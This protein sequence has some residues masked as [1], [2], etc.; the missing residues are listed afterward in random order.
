M[1]LIPMMTQPEQNSEMLKQIRKVVAAI[2]QIER[3]SV[4]VAGFCVLD[5]LKAQRK[6]VL[7]LRNDLMV[8]QSK[9]V[10]NGPVSGLR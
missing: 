1:E 5:T 10:A 7:A 3:T 9:L 2:D 8:R 4:F 6:Q